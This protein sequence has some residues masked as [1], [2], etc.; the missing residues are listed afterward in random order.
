MFN[1]C[2]LCGLERDRLERQRPGMSAPT[3]GCQREARSGVSRGAGA[4]DVAGVDRGQGR[5]R[6]TPRLPT[7]LR[8]W[9]TVRCCGREC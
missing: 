8:T 1:T 3:K 7:V 4:H 5:T 6:I 2:V 9:A